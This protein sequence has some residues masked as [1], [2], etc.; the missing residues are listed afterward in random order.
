MRDMIRGLCA[1]TVLCGLAQ[2]FVPEGSE[3][4]T[5]NLVCAVV[6]AAGFLRLFRPFD[7][8]NY[9]LERTELQIREE[10]YL[11]RNEEKLRSL[12]RRVIEAEYG[13]YILD[14]AA[15]RGL[16]LRE[17]RVQAQWSMEGLWL[18]YALTVVGEATE[19][20]KAMLEAKIEADLG[21][22]G[23]RQIWRQDSG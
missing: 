6:L 4:R 9:A 7:W 14:I 3:K 2:C 13:A 1:L 19:E 5:M 16:H 18:P 20:E 8:E 22:P 10:E 11:K 17:A 15:Q 23:Q 12:D 21:I